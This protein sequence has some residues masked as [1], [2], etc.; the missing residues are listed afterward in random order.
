[1]ELCL[2]AWNSTSHRSN[3]W[4]GRPLF[5]FLSNFTQNTSNAQCNLVQLTQFITWRSVPLS[6][7][8]LVL[9]LKLWRRCSGSWCG[10]R[11]VWGQ[12]GSGGVAAGCEEELHPAEAGDR[13][14]GRRPHRARA[15][16]GGEIGHL[17][18]KHPWMVSLKLEQIASFWFSVF[19][20]E[21]MLSFARYLTQF[22]AAKAGL[23]LVLKHLLVAQLDDLCCWL[24]CWSS[25]F[26]NPDN[27]E[28]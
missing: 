25:T 23:I 16:A 19:L 12:R 4:T 13:G 10:G 20:T 8:D 28:V 21:A 14:T 18:A 7:D 5:T 24:L 22:A 2:R 3:H 9:L 1:M 27:R 17:G 11:Q 15:Q 26:H 6:Q